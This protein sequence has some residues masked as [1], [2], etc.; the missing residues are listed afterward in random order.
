VTAGTKPAASPAYPPD[1]ATKAADAEGGE[2]M[3]SKMTALPLPAPKLQWRG[4]MIG[5][6]AAVIVAGGVAAYAALRTDRAAPAAP[7]GITA[8]QASGV[9]SGLGL[10]QLA[11]LRRA[12]FEGRAGL[13]APGDPKITDLA[14]LDV[15]QALNAAEVAIPSRA[16]TDSC[17]T[18]HRRC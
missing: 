3:S 17:W 2:A 14:R 11:R 15:R 9:A 4:W 18:I 16:A 7:A 1:T 8:G 5:F 6:L 12:D 10:D 13:S